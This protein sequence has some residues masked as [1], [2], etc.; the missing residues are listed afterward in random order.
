[1][2]FFQKLFRE[3]DDVMVSS[4]NQLQW[5]ATKF[6]SRPLDE[7]SS[8]ISHIMFFFLTF[9]YLPNMFL[10]TASGWLAE[11]HNSPCFV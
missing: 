2:L 4:Q 3:E 5:A 9:L 7:S 1:M 6:E 10:H 11:P 8:V